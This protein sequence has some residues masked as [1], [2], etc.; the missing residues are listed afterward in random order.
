[1]TH[2]APLEVGDLGALRAAVALPGGDNG[3]EREMLV[4]LTE[5]VLVPPSFA[6]AVAGI[7]AGTVATFA[8][9]AI[10][11]GAGHPVWATLLRDA[12]FAAAIVLGPEVLPPPND[13]DWTVMLVATAV[14]FALSIVYGCTFALAVRTRRPAP[15]AGAGLAF[16]A[17]V[18]GVNMYGF[19][20]AFPW[21]AATR[22]WITLAAHLVFGAGLGAAFAWLL[23]GGNRRGRRRIAS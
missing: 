11:W 6:G 13:F 3:R 19:T 20:A 12:R 16:G 10:W 23:G 2:G 1:M 9:M 15:A 21:F 14:H 4:P 7:A 17:I 8:Q 18:Y 22:D 5:G